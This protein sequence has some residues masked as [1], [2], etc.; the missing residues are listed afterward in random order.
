[1]GHA[2]Q[3]N[4]YCPRTSCEKLTGQSCSTGSRGQPPEWL[5]AQV[6]KL[7]TSEKVTGDSPNNAGT[8]SLSKGRCNLARQR[9]LSQRQGA[10]GCLEFLR[11]HAGSSRAVLCDSRV[12]LASK[13]PALPDPKQFGSRTS[14]LR[15]KKLQ[16]IKV[17][18]RRFLRLP[19]QAASSNRR[20]MRK[21]A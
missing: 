5:E 20:R 12:K 2:V 3:D 13:V 15:C 18:S 1:M 16:W 14:A 21:R 11:S 19:R 8:M 17:P 7:A 4:R 9:A 6:T 10:Q